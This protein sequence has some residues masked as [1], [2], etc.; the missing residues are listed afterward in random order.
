[1]D[2][3]HLVIV[4]ALLW[5]AV[6]DVLYRRIGNPVVLALLLAW[7]AHAG[8][9]LSAGH[10]AALTPGVVAGAL[11]LVAGYLLFVMGWMG[12]GDAKL[13]AVLCL[14]LGGEQTPVFLMV[15]ALAGGLLALAMP[16]LRTLE[17][18]LALALMRV[19]T[20]LPRPAIPLPQALGSQP[21][22]GIP[23]GLA[24][25]SGAAFVLWG[26]G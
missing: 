2:L 17:R 18:A 6:T 25:A 23:Y 19:D 5:I 14:W 26:G 4:P 8:W 22:S 24:I 11:V 1:M 15:T 21:A 3:A 10:D 7:L 16:L 13:M 12:A 20:W 9:Q